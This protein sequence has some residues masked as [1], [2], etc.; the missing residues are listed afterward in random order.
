[1]LGICFH[2]DPGQVGY[3]DNL[4][5]AF[6]VD[7]VVEL[8]GPGDVW[9]TAAEVPDVPRVV[10]SPQDAP[11]M[12]GVTPLTDFVHDDTLLYVFGHDHV[13]NPLI[14]ASDY[15]YVPIGVGSSLWSFQ[16]AAVVLSDFV[17]RHG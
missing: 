6:A 13:H 17:T 7:T 16:A 5:R 4:I 2:H 14:P 8:N 15:V 10:F 12:P 1:M 11:L 3:W 9:G